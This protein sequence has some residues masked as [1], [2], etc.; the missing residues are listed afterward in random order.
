MA[1]IPTALVTGSI[2]KTTTTRMLAHVLRG[3]GRRVAVG[4]TSGAQLDNLVFK[5]EDSAHG[6]TIRQFLQDPRVEVVVGE[7]SR[8]GL[9]K[10]GLR[11][12]EADVGAMLN[13]LDAHLGEDGVSTRED[14]LQIKSLVARAA[15]QALVLN[16]DDPLLRGV[17]DRQASCEHCL[18]GSMPPHGLLRDHLASGGLGALWRDGPDGVVVLCRGDTTLCEIPA[19][20]IQGAWGGMCRATVI[21]AAFVAVMSERMGVAPDLIRERILGF[22]ASLNPGRAERI[23]TPG[24]SIVLSWAGTPEA[25]RSLAVL[26]ESLR[27]ELHSRTRILLRL[28]FSAADHWMCSMAAEACRLFDVVDIARGES[29]A[30]RVEEEAVAMILEAGFGADPGVD[31]RYVGEVHAAIPTFL[32]DAAPGDPVLVHALDVHTAKARILEWLHTESLDR[33]E[34]LGA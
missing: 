15:T 19:A 26:M 5:Q 29:C 28:G 30:D 13:I 16:V 34:V 10:G 11:L 8:G 6:G 33:S 21:A 31:L 17:Y 2:G 12:R 22:D 24:Q 23:D 1:R 18:V 27:T 9:L 25:L 3:T 32:K 4:S 7:V 14:L 20:E